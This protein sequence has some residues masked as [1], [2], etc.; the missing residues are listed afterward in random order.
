MFSAINTYGVDVINTGEDLSL[1]ETGIAAYW[2]ANTLFNRYIIPVPLVS[3]N[4]DLIAIK[5]TDPVSFGGISTN[6][7]YPTVFDANFVSRL[8]SG[9]YTGNLGYSN[10]PN[11]GHFATIRKHPGN[12]G[13]SP[14]HFR[15]YRLGFPPV[16][17][18]SFGLNV[19]DSNKNLIFSSGNP[20]PSI[21]SY[22]SFKGAA[23]VNTWYQIPNSDGTWLML[24]SSPASIYTGG[25]RYM[26]FFR[27]FNNSWQYGFFQVGL[28][29]NINSFT[30]YKTQALF[31]R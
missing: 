19:W 7:S 23:N 9:G 31:L 5:S 29:G 10:F 8:R 6:K 28:S 2:D 24:T 27:Y 16:S 12:S 15:R 20:K 11:N 3:L 17:T 30:D 18:H 22:I 4:Q 25:K 21:A 14:V 13:N 26:L 1:V